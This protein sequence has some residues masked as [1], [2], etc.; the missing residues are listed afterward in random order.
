M[1]QEIRDMIQDAESYSNDVSNIVDT[2]YVLEQEGG[3]ITLSVYTK[4]SNKNCM[5]NL[6]I[7]SAKRCLKVLIDVYNE[8]IKELQSE[9][10]KSFEDLIRN[11]KWEKPGDYI[12]Y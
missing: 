4:S 8:K 1:R 9:V 5:I 12:S 11:Y 2:L 3:K 10:N 7:E 6:D